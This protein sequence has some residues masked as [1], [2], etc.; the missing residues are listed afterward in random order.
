V[1]GAPPGWHTSDASAPPLGGVK[2]SVIWPPSSMGSM[3]TGAS[4]LSAVKSAPS[5][6]ELRIACGALEMKIAAIW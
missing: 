5:A 2:V 1:A 3:T 4:A 6:G